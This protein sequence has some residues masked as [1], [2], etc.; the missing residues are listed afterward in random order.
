MGLEMGGGECGRNQ[1]GVQPEA[2]PLVLEGSFGHI[3]A[4]PWKWHWG[5]GF[6]SGALPRQQPA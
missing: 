3:L 2:F 1:V 5:L 4:C 6:T